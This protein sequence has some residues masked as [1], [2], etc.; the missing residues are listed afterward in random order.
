MLDQPESQINGAQ[1]DCPIAQGSPSKIKGILHLELGLPGAEENIARR[2]M[3][4]GR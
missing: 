2:K 1:I 3:V 4:N